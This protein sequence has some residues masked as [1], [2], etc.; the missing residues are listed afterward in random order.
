MGTH[1]STST[2]LVLWGCGGTETLLHPLGILGESGLQHLSKA[3]HQ[4]SSLSPE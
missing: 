3:A 2:A 1:K 4:Q